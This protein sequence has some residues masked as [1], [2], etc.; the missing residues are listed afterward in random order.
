MADD[1]EAP[2]V[3]EKPEPERPWE[4]GK[5]TPAEAIEVLERKAADEEISQQALMLGGMRTAPYPKYM[6]DALVM[7]YVA[8]MLRLKIENEKKGRR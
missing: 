7:R 2:E 8:N 5:V 3:E 1:P 4:I 6:R